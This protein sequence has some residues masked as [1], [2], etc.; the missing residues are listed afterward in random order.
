MTGPEGG[1]YSHN[2]FKV[3]NDIPRN[4]QEDEASVSESGPFAEFSPDELKLLEQGPMNQIGWFTGFDHADFA[5][6]ETTT[7][8]QI[9]KYVK[10]AD[11]ATRKGM[12]ADIVAGVE[13]ASDDAYEAE[14]RKVA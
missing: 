5:F 10:T 13:K 4:R 8:E 9:R 11:S 7:L 12:E 2:T 1:F 14:N 6:L 3:D